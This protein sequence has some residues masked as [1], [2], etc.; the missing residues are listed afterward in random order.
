MDELLKL[1]ADF[2]S[3][4]TNQPVELIREGVDNNTYSFYTRAGRKVVSKINGREKPEFVAG[5]IALIES[6]KKGGARVATVITAIDGSDYKILNNKTVVCF[7]FIDNNPIDHGS[8]YQADI[9]RVGKAGY[10]LGKFHGVSIKLKLDSKHRK[11]IFSELERAI[12][13]RKKIMN[14]YKGG[15]KFI[16]DVENAL[17]KSKK[18][19][20]D[21]G[22][23]H[24]DYNIS[25]VLFKESRMKAIIDF[26]L[27]CNGPLLMD[28]GFGAASW[29]TA[30]GSV[31]PQ[32]EA[33]KSFINGY[34]KSSPI[35]V[36]KDRKLYFWTAFSCLNIACDLL[37]DSLTNNIYSISD[38]NQSWMYGRYKHY[39]SLR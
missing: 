5:E 8:K 23:I 39:I 6:L 3:A 34:N 10:A 25:N 17:I 32:E 21:W 28:V 16:K 15:D 13:N 20:F 36:T 12:L 26:D 30:N 2:Y 4:D 19:S 11:T 18:G 35:K 1:L 24:N 7:E 22:V 38:V 31:V 29:S 14:N 9:N 27:A 33:F 37:C